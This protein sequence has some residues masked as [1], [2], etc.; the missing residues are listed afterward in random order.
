M[1]DTGRM[2][3]IA[4]LHLGMRVRCTVS[5][6]PPLAPVDA[7]GTIEGFD[8]HPDDRTADADPEPA[9]RVL[10]QLPRAVI[11]K[12]D[13]IA[14]DLLP[15]Q[16]CP[17]HAATEASRTCL[18]CQWFPGHIAITPKLSPQFV[19]PVTLQ[20]EDAPEAQTFQLK[21]KRRQIPLTI[22]TASTLHTLQG[23]TTDPGLI[24]HWNFPK[25][26]G[27]EMKWLAT[28]VALSRSRSLS[29]LRSIGLTKWVRK[30]VEEGPPEG[31]LTRFADLF[32]DKLDK[33]NLAA[34]EAMKALGWK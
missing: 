34:E 19:L 12:L 23:A 28:Y 5:V 10:R 11:L 1:S 32:N 17:A 29:N 13:D 30:T 21:I 9:I 18:S 26:L 6:E 33:T 8:F 15:P 3:G 31:V 16:P 24:F 20:T 27:K 2:P 14:A 4:M 25:R 22:I 7:T